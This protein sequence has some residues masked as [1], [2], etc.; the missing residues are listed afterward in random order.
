[1]SPYIEHCY[2]MG[3]MSSEVLF[4]IINNSVTCRGVWSWLT[5][6]V[7]DWMIGFIDTFNI[8]KTRDYRQYGAIALLHILQFTVTRTHARTHTLGFSVFISRI[9]ATDLSVSLLLQLT[10][11]VCFAPLNSFSC[12]YFATAKSE[13]S[14]P[15]NSKLI[16]WQAEVPKLDSS[17]SNV[18]QSATSSDCVLL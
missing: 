10:Y 8:H 14:A 16:S 15:F 6:W 13:D 7:L 12:P 3:N 9:L 17:F 5:R 1:M 4:G 2:F 11:E 18:L